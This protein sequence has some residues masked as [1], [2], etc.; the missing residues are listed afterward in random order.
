MG[1]LENL[2]TILKNTTSNAVIEQINHVFQFNIEEKDKSKEDKVKLLDDVTNS[3]F[4]GDNEYNT[5]TLQSGICITPLGE[6][7]NSVDAEQIN[8]YKVR[9]NKLV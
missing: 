7:D 4:L 1:I 8:V 9:L 6:L 3:I 2:K 5:I